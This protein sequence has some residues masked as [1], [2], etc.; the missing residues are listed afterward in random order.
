MANYQK[1]YECYIDKL[2]TDGFKI[3]RYARKSP[4]ELL[5]DEREAN[6]QTM[7]NCLRERSLAELIYVSPQ[8]LAGSLIDSRDMPSVVEE[9]EKMELNYCAGSIQ[10]KF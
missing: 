2:K 3:I 4:D 8:C 6:L 5:N 1:R 7:I 10:S 9:L